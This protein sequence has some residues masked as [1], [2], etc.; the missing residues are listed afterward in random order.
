[1]SNGISTL[2]YLKRIEDGAVF[3]YTEQLARLVDFTEIS[4]AEA[5]WRLGKGEKPANTVILEDLPP[6]LIAMLGKFDP[7]QIGLLTDHAKAISVGG[8]INLQPKIDT[9]QPPA[10]DTLT[11]PATGQEKTDTDPATDPEEQITDMQKPIDKMTKAEIEVY[12]LSTHGKRFEDAETKAQML[13]WIKAK[14]AK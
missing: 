2:R 14:E 13:E 7:S 10:I 3:T 12:A 4:H 1:M 11:P 8:A 5:M 9:L 6:E